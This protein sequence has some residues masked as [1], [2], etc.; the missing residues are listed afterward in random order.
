[1]ADDPQPE[2]EAE[3]EAAVRRLEVVVAWRQ[4]ALDRALSLGSRNSSVL[5]GGRDTFLKEAFE[6][7]DAILA[8][9]GKPSW[10]DYLTRNSN[11]I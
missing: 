3:A 4:W 7:A 11:R 9:I 10:R 1:M 6:D 5:R 2:T 8:W